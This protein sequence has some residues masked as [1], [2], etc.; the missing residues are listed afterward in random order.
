MR[1]TLRKYVAKMTRPFR[2]RIKDVLDGRY[3][4]REESQRF[5]S[6]AVVEQLI[7]DVD[8]LAENIRGL[9][10]DQ[11]QTGSRDTLI[12]PENP[13]R[14][15]NPFV[16]RRDPMSTSRS[17]DASSIDQPLSP[18]TDTMIEREWL[19]VYLGDILY[20]LVGHKD[21]LVCRT[22]R[23]WG[24]WEPVVSRCLVDILRAA[25]PG[26]GVVVDVG[27][28]VGYYSLLAASLG[29]ETHAVEPLFGD[30]ILAAAHRN[31]FDDLVHL[32]R[33]AVGASRGVAGMYMFRKTGLSYLSTSERGKPIAAWHAEET[34]DKVRFVD[35]IPVQT[36]DELTAPL[37]EIIFLKIDVEGHEPAVVNGFQNGLDRRVAQW[38]QLEVTPKWLGA[39]TA[40]ELIDRICTH[41]YD[42]FDLGLKHSGPFPDVEMIDSHELLNSA[43]VRRLLQ[44]S[45]QR[46]FLFKRQ[47]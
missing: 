31:G 16:L 2:T 36:L 26:D 4:R 23:R 21:E 47:D 19:T 42:V 27:A 45:V 28:H 13:E 18:S 41:G 20:D 9:A 29:Y 12:G 17:D 33:V 25:T 40:G 37:R 7:A 3:L 14:L 1:N 46:D 38:I 5:V 32:H 11:P 6:R 39:K 15:S 30:D 10:A 24:G 22:I 43:D 34:E 35:G 8:E 44:H